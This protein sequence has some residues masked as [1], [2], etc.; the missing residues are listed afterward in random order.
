MTEFPFGADLSNILDYKQIVVVIPILIA[1][2]VKPPT[3]EDLKKEGLGYTFDRI[4]KSVNQKKHD[5]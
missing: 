4:L 5:T 3:I 2:G 1:R